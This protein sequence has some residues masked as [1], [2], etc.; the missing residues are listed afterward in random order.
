MGKKDA[1][2]EKGQGCDDQLVQLKS[3]A[4]IK[5]DAIMDE[6][7]A[8]FILTV[9]TVQARC[10]LGGTQDCTAFLSPESSSFSVRV[11]GLTLMF[12]AANDIFCL[13]LKEVNAENSGAVL[14][15][16]VST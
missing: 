9:G 8:R 1:K 12:F 11:Q 4:Q 14:D 2:K 13:F 10:M 5:L 15:S 6:I 3:P 16:A 7:S